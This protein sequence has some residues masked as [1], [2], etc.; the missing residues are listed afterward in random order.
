MQSKH[1]EEATT[2]RRKWLNSNKKKMIIRRVSKYQPSKNT[3]VRKRSAKT[4]G[5]R[6]KQDKHLFYFREHVGEKHF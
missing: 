2:M 5:F 3:D 6:R 1:K 4:N